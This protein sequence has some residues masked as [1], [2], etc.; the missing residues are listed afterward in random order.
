MNRDNDADKRPRVYLH[1]STSE[2]E[3]EVTVQG[4]EGEGAEHE[5]E[6]YEAKQRSFSLSYCR[7]CD[8]EYWSY[9]LGGEN[10]WNYTHGNGDGIPYGD[11]WRSIRK[12]IL[13]RD[14][15]SCVICGIGNEE[16][17]DNFGGKSLNVH[18]II[19]R[20]EFYDG[21][22]LDEEANEPDNLVTLCHRHHKQV[23]AN[24]IQVTDD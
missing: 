11:G 9:R 2:Q 19:P 10:H 1:S 4:A 21:E 16:H 12:T 18:H 14:D 5:Y 17:Q 3:I 24:E 6:K 23:E 22:T 15:W 13:E 20:S 7:E 8:S